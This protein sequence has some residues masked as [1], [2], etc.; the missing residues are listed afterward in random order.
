[1]IYIDSKKHN[2]RINNFIQ[3]N[4][5]SSEHYIHISQLKYMMPWSMDDYD[6]SSVRR[7]T[8]ISDLQ[9]KKE[10]LGTT[11]TYIVKD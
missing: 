1:M 8:T 3:P 5:P 11:N 7:K 4:K 6:I 9:N 2:N 10:Y